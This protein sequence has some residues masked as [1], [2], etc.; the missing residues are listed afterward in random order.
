[1][2]DSIQDHGETFGMAF[3]AGRGR[4]HFAGSNLTP[5]SSREFLSIIRDTGRSPWFWI[6]LI[7]VPPLT[8]LASRTA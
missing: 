3:D 1:M 6:T 5:E 2:P 4:A 7:V 8:A